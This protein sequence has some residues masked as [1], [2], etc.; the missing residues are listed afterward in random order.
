MN[1]TIFMKSS[2]MGLARVARVL[3]VPFSQAANGRGMCF[4]GGERDKRKG[5]LKKQAS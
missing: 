2:P 1:D 4:G 3:E 5:N